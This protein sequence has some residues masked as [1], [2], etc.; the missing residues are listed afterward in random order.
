MMKHLCNASKSQLGALIYT[1]SQYPLHARHAL[2][3][4]IKRGT[5]YCLYIYG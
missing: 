1:L 5:T 3:E 4:L 2:A